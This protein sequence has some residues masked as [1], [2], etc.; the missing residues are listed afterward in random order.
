MRLVGHVESTGEGRGFN[1]VL[2][3]R[4]EGKRPLGRPRRRWEDNIK[5]DLREKEIDWV[6]WIW[7]SQDRFH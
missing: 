4:P 1:R 3:G 5:M 7:L 6:N 2:V